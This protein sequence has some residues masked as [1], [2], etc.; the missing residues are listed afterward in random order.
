MPAAGGVCALWVVPR[1]RLDRERLCG[2][3]SAANYRSLQT[4]RPEFAKLPK[5][6][7]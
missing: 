4:S 1:E 5:K 2:Y 3:M 7:L 6:T